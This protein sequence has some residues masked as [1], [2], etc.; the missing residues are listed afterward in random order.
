MPKARTWLLGAMLLALG[1]GCGD[2]TD[3]REGVR[4][5]RG[6]PDQI[7]QGGGGPYWYEMWYYQEDGKLYEFR[8]SAPKCG[9]GYDY[10]LYATY[11]EDAAGKRSSARA[12]TVYHTTSP[13]S[14]NPLG[15]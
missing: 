4:A 13:P 12:D 2:P 3:A 8:R 9:G 1:I 7:K 15:P 10:Y 5:R 14:G 6:E 11:Y